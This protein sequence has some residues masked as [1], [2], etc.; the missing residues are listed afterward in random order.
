MYV[1]GKIEATPRIYRERIFPYPFPLSSTNL[2]NDELDLSSVEIKESSSLIRCENRGI[3]VEFEI[4]GRQG[5][6]RILIF[7]TR[8]F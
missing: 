6:K 8:Y 5:G 2:D 4:S 1:C 7:L 3:K